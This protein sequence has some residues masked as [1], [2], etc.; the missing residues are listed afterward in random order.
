MTKL[1]T[2]Q[3]DRK[4]ETRE[5]ALAR[6]KARNKRMKGFKPSQEDSAA[7]HV[8]ASDRRIR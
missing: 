5:D 2:L 1:N 7:A 6:I 8:P 3:T 4:N